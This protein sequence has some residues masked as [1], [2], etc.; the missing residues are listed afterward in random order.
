[1]GL[2]MDKCTKIFFRGSDL[3]SNNMYQKVDYSKTVK[4]LGIHFS[5]ILSQKIHIEENE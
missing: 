4:D 3:I 1:M 2:A 5:D